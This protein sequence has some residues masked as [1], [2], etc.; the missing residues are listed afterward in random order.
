MKPSTKHP[1]LVTSRDRY[2]LGRLLVDAE[3]R[4]YGDRHS[5]LELG[6]A[7]EESTLSRANSADNAFVSMNSKVRLL[8]L[9]SERRQEVSLVYPDDVDLGPHCVSVLEPLGVALLGR[10]AGDV[11][12]CRRR[13]VPSSY[14]IADVAPPYQSKPDKLSDEIPNSAK[15]PPCHLPKRSAVFDRPHR[16]PQPAMT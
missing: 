14:R 7:L 4:A 1:R 13:G 11:V 2:R 15:K 8:D 3:S 5:R 16:S 10:Q 12:E 9:S 6:F